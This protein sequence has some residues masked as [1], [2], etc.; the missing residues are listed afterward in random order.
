[1]EG[2]TTTNDALLK[3]W[4]EIANYFGKGV[5]TVQRWE[6]E[7][8]LPVRRPEG[9]HAKTAVFAHAADLEAWLESNWSG[10]NGRHG[11]IETKTASDQSVEDLIRTVA[12][13]RSYHRELMLDAA[14]VMK[15]LAARCARFEINDQRGNC[16]SQRAENNAKFLVRRF[17]LN[18]DSGPPHEPVL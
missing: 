8:G 18:P 6:Q 1:M 15:I 3:S 13:L 7:Y 5:R 17:G 10:G 11:R 16:H 4:E 9:A 12:Q 14:E 2:G